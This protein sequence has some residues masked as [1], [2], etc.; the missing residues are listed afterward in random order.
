MT[1]CE[2]EI[3]GRLYKLKSE[4]EEDIIKYAD[5]LNK[6]LSIVEKKVQTIDDHVIFSLTGINI[7]EEFFN[8]KKEN[9]RLKKEIKELSDLADKFINENNI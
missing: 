2:V 9:E 6:R 1:S 5:F 7:A 8:L 3:F 4:N